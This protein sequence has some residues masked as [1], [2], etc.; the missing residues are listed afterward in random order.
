[1][2]KQPGT[3]AMMKQQKSADKPGKAQQRVQKLVDRA[4]RKAADAKQRQTLLEDS[5]KQATAGFLNTE[6]DT[7]LNFARI[8]LRTHDDAHR[9][10]NQVQARRAYDTLQKHLGTGVHEGKESL[11]TIH[12]KF[13]KLR[14]LLISL[15]EKL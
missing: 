5:F 1:M 13:K 8:A 6:A 7:G 4:R 9:N 15:G 14:D 11:D 3:P 10:R 12:V 2:R